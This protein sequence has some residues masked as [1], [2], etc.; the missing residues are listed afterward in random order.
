M[1][2]VHDVYSKLLG[3]GTPFYF[4]LFLLKSLVCIYEY[5]VIT[6]LQAEM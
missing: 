3:E 6:K 2:R 4:K 5:D 1:G